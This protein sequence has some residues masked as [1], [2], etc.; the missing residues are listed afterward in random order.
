[1]TYPYE[2]IALDVDGTV[3]NSKHE[4]SPAHVAELQRLVQTGVHV[5]LATG[6]QLFAVQ[7]LIDRLGLVAPQITSD[8]A[9]ISQAGA[10]IYRQPVPPD[11]AAQFIRVGQEIGI[12]VILAG[13]SA[14]IT[15]ALNPDIEYMLTYGD[16]Y[17]TFVPDLTFA[18]D[19]PPDYLMA[20]AY[21]NEALYAE[22]ERV[23]KARF[24]DTLRI[25]R[26][27]PYYIQ[28]LHPDASKG[29]AIRQVCEMLH[30][31]LDKTIAVGDSFN[32]LSMF[33][34]VGRAVSMGHSADAVKAAAHEVTGTLDED[35]VAQVIRKYFP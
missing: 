1:M 17:P 12:S 15:T 11:L 7:S 19:P 24:G 18:L 22:A 4:V 33:A 8:G 16:P 3:Q 2:L 23:F 26:T 35:G 14:T 31:P 25:H 32:D 10:V 6:K 9:I 5:V 27:S 21:Q 20:I 29:N 34:V 30:V 28:A 13:N